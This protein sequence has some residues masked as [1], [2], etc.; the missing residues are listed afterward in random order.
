MDTQIEQPP[1]LEAEEIYLAE[2]A[3]PGESLFL[4]MDLGACETPLLVLLFVTGIGFGIM[5]ATIALG[6]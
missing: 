4:D 1:D 2:R 5:L 6:W 3:G